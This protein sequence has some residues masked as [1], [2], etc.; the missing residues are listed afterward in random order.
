MRRLAGETGVGGCEHG[1]SGGHS[2]HAPTE[3]DTME[4]RH[5]RYFVAVAE[6][7]HFRR[8]AE[9]LHI[10]QPAISEQ[11]RKLE[12]EL[13]VQLFDR[14]PRCVTLTPSGT[15]LLDEARRVLRQAE[16]A[17]RAACEADQRVL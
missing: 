6:E 4:L 3:T 13:G 9:R 5:L 2:S 7:L 10:A 1:L 17:R 14:G 16:V 11:I 12:A 8:A 15:A